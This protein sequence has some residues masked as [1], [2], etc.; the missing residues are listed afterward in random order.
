MNSGTADATNISWRIHV[1]GGVLGRI[2]ETISGTI[3]VLAPGHS[4]TFSTGM[5]FGFGKITITAQADEV[6]KTVT[7]T[8]LFIFTMV[9]T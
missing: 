7:G 8:Q 5:F 2:N 6:I 4:T 3:D 1:Q 9:N